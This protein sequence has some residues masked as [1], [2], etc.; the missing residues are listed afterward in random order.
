MRSAS[1]SGSPAALMCCRT[2]TGNP[3]LSQV[4][5]SATVC[6][7][8]CRGSS[9]GAGCSAVA[10]SSVP[11]SPLAGSL[12]D[13]GLSF[14]PPT[15]ATSACGWVSPLSSALGNACAASSASGGLFAAL[16][17]FT[18]LSSASPSF[19]GLSIACSD[20]SILL[21]SLSWGGWCTTCS[22]LGVLSAGASALGSWALGCNG[23]AC[24]F[25]CHVRCSR[26]LDFPFGFEASRTGASASSGAFSW[27]PS[28]LMSSTIAATSSAALS[29]NS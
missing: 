9:A 5:Q 8:R 19:G 21:A 10:F 22:T 1:F 17:A 15:A 25:T 24:S 4:R 7:A 13:G 26:P 28:A 27:A 11:A 2:S 29:T 16:S 23:L 3:W 20:L 12:M 18:G 6:K 14:A